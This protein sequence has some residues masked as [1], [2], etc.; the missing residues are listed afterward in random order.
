M[1]PKI[2]RFFVCDYRYVEQIKACFT[3]AFTSTLNKLD[4]T[5][6]MTFTRAHRNGALVLFLECLIITIYN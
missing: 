6:H 4:N 2:K 1:R 3:I 5:L